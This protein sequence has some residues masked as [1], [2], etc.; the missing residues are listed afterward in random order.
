VLAEGTRF[1]ALAWAVFD[2]LDAY[3]RF[4]A[5]LEATGDSLLATDR[6]RVFDLGR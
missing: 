4:R 5:R 6:V 1:F 3:P 2:W